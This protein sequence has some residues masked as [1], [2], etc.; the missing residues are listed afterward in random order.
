MDEKLW[1]KIA[2]AFPKLLDYGVRVTVPLTAVSFIL[3]LIISVAVA[4]A[5]YANVKGL[6]HICRFYIWAIRG[7]PVLVQL[8]I[9]FYGLARVGIKI[10]AYVAAI[11]VFAINEGAYMAESMRGALESVSRGQ[12]EAGYCVGLNYFRIMRHIV[13]PQAF[14]TAF[15]SLWN[16]LIS[17]LKGTSLA[18]TITV[19]EMF[20]EGQIIVGQ[21]FE[22]LAIYIEVALIYLMFCTILTF[23]QKFIEKRLN[24]YGGVK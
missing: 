23:L 2:D 3:A 13:L 11:A 5:L 16:S 17:M 22:A 21:N 19:V 8:F 12:I 20:R 14:R 6:K 10:D 18:A 4:M 15:P 9:V 1:E 7:T 24:R